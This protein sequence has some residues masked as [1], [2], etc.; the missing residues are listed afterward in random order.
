MSNLSNSNEQKHRYKTKS[1]EH[2]VSEEGDAWQERCDLNDSVLASRIAL[3]TSVLR[4]THNIKSV[5]EFG[6]GAGHSLLAV[7]TLLPDA[8]Y[9]A[10]EINAKA[11]EI[12]KSNM[13]SCEVFPGSILEN[14]PPGTYDFVFTGGLL[15]CIEGKYLPIAYDNIY[16]HSNRY[17]G[18]IEYYNPTPVEIIYRG[19]SGILFKRDF[20]GEMLD[21]YPDLTL[22]DY[23]FVYHRDA[24]F[25]ADDTNWFLLEK[26]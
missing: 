22:V 6:P 26:R 14:K 8:S 20:V 18:I 24:N 16:S 4:R 1:E 25:P 7:K 3:Y 13:P 17:I 5:F 15:V 10:M 21:K 12:L 9:S 23:G 11:A 19:K 2:W